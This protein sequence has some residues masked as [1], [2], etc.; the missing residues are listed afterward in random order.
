MKLFFTGLGLK[1]NTS[2]FDRILNTILHSNQMQT[3]M[4]KRNTYLGNFFVI[5]HTET[6][7]CLHYIIH[8]NQFTGHALTTLMHILMMVL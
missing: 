1:G 8:F 2:C 6:I 4:L 7:C 5:M 3:K